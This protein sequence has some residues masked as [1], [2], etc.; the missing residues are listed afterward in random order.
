MKT[1][2]CFTKSRYW[3]CILLVGCG[4]LIGALAYPVF[5][6]APADPYAELPTIAEPLFGSG[7]G[8]G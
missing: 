7:G 5:D 8:P 2:Y 1:S 4:L 3:L 6:V